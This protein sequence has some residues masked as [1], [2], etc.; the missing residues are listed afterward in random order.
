MRKLA[1]NRDV[2]EC[3]SDVDEDFITSLITM[4]QKEFDFEFFRWLRKQGLKRM[5]MVPKLALQYNLAIKH[6]EYPFVLDDEFILQELSY[7][8]AIRA[9]VPD[10]RI[11]LLIEM[12]K[13]PNNRTFKKFK[14][15]VSYIK[16][17]DLF[18]VDLDIHPDFVNIVEWNIT[19]N[20]IRFAP[21]DHCS[22][23]FAFMYNLKA[24]YSVEIAQT[25]VNWKNFTFI[26]KCLNIRI[27][28]LIDCEFI[29]IKDFSRSNK[30][31]M[32]CLSCTSI[33]KNYSPQELLKMFFRS[34]PLVGHIFFCGSE[35]N[36]IP[37]QSLIDLDWSI[38]PKL[39]SL[40]YES[41]D[42]LDIG[43]FDDLFSVLTVQEFKIQMKIK[44]KFPTLRNGNFARLAKCSFLF[45]IDTVHDHADIISFLSEFVHIKSVFIEFGIK[46]GVILMTSD[47]EHNLNNPVFDMIEMNSV[48]FMTLTKTGDKYLLSPETFT[49]VKAICE[50]FDKQLPTGIKIIR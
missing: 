40:Y 43:L 22:F 4:M 13:K 47:F 6:Q 24:L 3:V 26:L 32:F 16:P 17:Y 2:Q 18:R 44:N 46:L 27:L 21:Q 15:M 36:K 31:K 42:Y 14:K 8:D 25:L 48:F 29:N 35:L 9:N 20:H 30:I 38:I 1:K 23:N 11:R 34:F 50:Y 49:Y 39:D 19:C 45:D 28:T 7:L 5:N 37:F 12:K 41:D 10:Y 33:F